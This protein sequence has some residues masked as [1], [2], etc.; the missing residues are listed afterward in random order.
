MLYVLH[1]VLPKLY[2]IF[3]AL[4]SY[5][6]LTGLSQVYLRVSKGLSLSKV[7][8]RYLSGNS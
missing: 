2:H 8:L 3:L 5:R 7:S 4:D 6:S 1:L